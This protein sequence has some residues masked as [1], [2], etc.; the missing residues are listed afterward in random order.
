MGVPKQLSG[1]SDE[2]LHKL[3]KVSGM[4]FWCF[5]GLLIVGVTLA[6][7]GLINSKTNPVIYIGAVIPICLLPLMWHNYNKTK[8]ELKR[9][10]LTF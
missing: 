8:A 10:N 7:Y 9:R 1:L 6:L 2:E 5:V 3:H 4:L